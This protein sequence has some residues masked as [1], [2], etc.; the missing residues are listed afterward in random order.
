MKATSCRARIRMLAIALLLAPCAAGAGEQAERALAVVKQMVAAGEVSRSAVIKVAFKSGNIAA[1]LG[2][3]LELQ[4]EWERRSGVMITARVIPQQPSVTNLKAN[5]DIDL[6]VARTNEF[7]DL[8]EQGL[9]EDLTPMLKQ[10]GFRLDGA[11]P[12]GYVRP[13]LQGY[14]GDKAV[15]IPADGD[16]LIMYLRRDLMEN[17]AERAAFRQ[18]HGREL[19]APKTWQ[20]YEELASFFHRPQQGLYGSVE[21]RERAGGWM[22]WLPRYLSQSAPYRK[23]FDENLKPLI[24]S[25]AG[26]AATESY[27]STVRNAPPDILGEGKD[28]SYTLPLFMQGKAFSSAFTIAGAKLLNSAASSVRG[29]FMAV[30]VPGTR[31]G[32]RLVRQNMPIYGNNLVVSSRGSQRKLAFLFAMWL[33]DPDNSLRTVGVKGGFTDPFRWHHLGDPRIKELYTPQALSVFAKEWAI[34]LPPGTGLPGDGE[35]LTVLDQHLWEAASGKVSA[36]EA[37]RHT[38]QDW[39]KITQRH[40]RDKQLPWLKIFHAGFAVSEPGG[41]VK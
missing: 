23:L 28:Y 6:T 41:A 18:A 30:P 3:E 4:R 31:V 15:A 39:E 29:K 20:E 32:G 40:G 8:L 25:P 12:Q 5:P 13:R 38:A 19:E 22:F 34:A 21:Q 16:V 17:P 24:D 7:P 33:T 35:Y 2:P 14:F 1:L 27:V 10:Y 26:I 9:V 36:A 11:P 37:M